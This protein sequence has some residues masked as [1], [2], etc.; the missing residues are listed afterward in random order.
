[1]EWIS[2]S[3]PARMTTGCPCARTIAGAASSPAPTPAMNSRRRIRNVIDALLCCLREMQKTCRLAQHPE[4][5]PHLPDKQLRLLEG[6]EMTALRHF[7]PVPDVGVA[8]LH[9]APHRRD[10]LLGKH[11]DAARDRHLVRRSA[12]WAKALPIQPRR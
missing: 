1:M 12:F 8:A 11:G 5:F 9:P 6:R 10:D 3:A 7:P 4:E 2:F